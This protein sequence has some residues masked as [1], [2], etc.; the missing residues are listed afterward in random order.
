MLTTRPNLALDHLVDRRLHELDRRQHVGVDRA[1]PR[2][3]I[4][5]AEVAGRRPARVGDEDVGVGTR[6]K[7]RRRGPR[8]S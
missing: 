2:V 7:R 4:E 3:A 5:L 6:R 1:N 8:V